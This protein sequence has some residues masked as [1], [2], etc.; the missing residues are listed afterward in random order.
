ML[1]RMS[2]RRK[3]TP[4]RLSECAEE[5]YLGSVSESVPSTSTASDS[6][7]LT[8]SESYQKRISTDGT[9]KKAK[10]LFALLY[11]SFH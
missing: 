6:A 7:M 5:L 1:F 11:F 2:G 10:S 9:S 8:D 3:T 4:N